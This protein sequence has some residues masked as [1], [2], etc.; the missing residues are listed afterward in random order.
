V[1]QSCK[2]LAGLRDHAIAANTRSD[3]RLSH[4]PGE[5]FTGNSVAPVRM[6]VSDR[7]DRNG[8][9]L[10]LRNSSQS[11]ANAPSLCDSSVTGNR[12]D[13]VEG[14]GWEFLFVA[15][16]DHARIGFLR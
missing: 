6:F 14:A 16:D 10:A 8:T 4:R 11:A 15:V 2:I 5:N 1:P 3:R 7:R 9:L 13:S 12:R